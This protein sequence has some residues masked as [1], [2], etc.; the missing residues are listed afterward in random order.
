[1]EKLITEEEIVP[2]D[3]DPILRAESISLAEFARLNN[4]L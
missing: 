3:I 2:M 1:M 4:L